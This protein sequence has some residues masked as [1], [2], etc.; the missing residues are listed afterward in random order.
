[1]ARGYESFAETVKAAERLHQKR[2]GLGQR[3][4]ADGIFDGISENRKLKHRMD[5]GLQATIRSPIPPCFSSGYEN[6]SFRTAQAPPS[7]DAI[8]NE[9]ARRAALSMG[10]Y[11]G[12]FETYMKM[13]LKAQAQTVRTVEVLA[14]IKKPPVVF[15]K[16]ANISNGPQQVNIGTTPPAHVRENQTEQTILLTGD[17]HATLDS[18]RTAATIGV[19]QELETVGAVNRA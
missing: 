18:S 7:L 6:I 13:A 2:G 11:I 14:A 9:L 19:N 8:F 1:L 17:G 10:E 4:V 16:Q 15:A 5:Y 12:S 3:L